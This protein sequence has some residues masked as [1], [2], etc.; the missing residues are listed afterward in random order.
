MTIA[1]IIRPR[2]YR[3]PI[4][5]PDVFFDDF[6]YT[7]DRAET[8]PGA[9]VAAH[10]WDSTFRTETIQAHTAGYIYTAAPADIPGYSGTFPGSSQR[11]LVTEGRPSIYDLS[12]PTAFKQTDH[13]IKY[14]AAGDARGKIPANGYYRWWMRTV[15]NATWPSTYAGSNKILYPVGSAELTGVDFYFTWML[16]CGCFGNEPFNPAWTVPTAASSDLYFGFS[17][18][19]YSG[20]GAVNTASSQY[21]TG[22]QRLYQNLDHSPCVANTWYEITVHVDAA[23]GVFELWTRAYGQARVKKIEFISG[24]TSGFTWTPYVDWLAGERQLS[25]PST[26]NWYN[27]GNGTY[28]PDGDN[29]K[30]W[31]DFSIATD[32]NNLR[33]YGDE[34]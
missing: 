16:V 12:G 32:S 25:L 8:S 3:G 17:L 30:L 6:N 4:G 13:Y 21:P 11:C 10:G 33:T 7:L 34:P 2:R 9:I 29:W 15:N 19:Q 18:Q 22:A 28:G 24:V 31:Q 26:E 14:G 20:Y 1:R 27:N 5:T 23:T